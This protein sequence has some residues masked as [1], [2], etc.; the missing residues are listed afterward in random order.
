MKK[1][2]FIVAAL[3][4][5]A[6][7]HPHID[8]GPAVSATGGQI[9]QFGVSHGCSGKDTVKITINIPT[10]ISG[11]RGLYSPFGAPTVTKNGTNV[12]S[13]TWEKATFEAGDNTYPEF[14][15]RLTVADVPFTS[16]PFT[17]VQTCRDATGDTVATWDQPDDSTG[18]AAP[19]LLVVPPHAGGWNK[20]TVPVALTQ[21]QVQQFFASSQIVWRG[22]AAYTPN[23]AV[24]GLIAVTPGV[25][26]LTDGLAAGDEIWVKY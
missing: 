11:V 16:I 25:T 23:A 22:T 15:L 10:G 12:T 21:D 7:A 3:A 20:Y 14:A 4:A 13:V 24:A 8:S 18:N 19:R 2:L 5:P 9:V 17:I 26:P 6:A 1:S